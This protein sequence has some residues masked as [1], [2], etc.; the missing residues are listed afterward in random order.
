MISRYTGMPPMTYMAPMKT[1][2][3]EAQNRASY[4]FP[5]TPMETDFPMTSGMNWQEANT[6]PPPPSG[7]MKSP[8]TVLNCPETMYNGRI[9]KVVKER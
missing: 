9:T 8:I 1:N 3:A 7:I 6:T 4:W 5:K 2:P